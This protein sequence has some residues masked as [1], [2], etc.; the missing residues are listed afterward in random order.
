LALRQP[1]QEEEEP[2]ANKKAFALG[3]C[4]LVAALSV[5][6]T[7]GATQPASARGCD[8][9]IRSG[10]DIARKVE[11]KPAG[12]T[13]CLTGRYRL[14]RPVSPRERQVFR[15]PASI[16]GVKGND[17]G[18]LVSQKGV[19]F[20]NLVMSGFTE[21]AIRCS[22]GTQIIGGRYH[23]NGVNGIGCGLGREGRGV[24]ISGVE[25]DH[26]GSQRYVFHSSAGIKIL[27][28]P[29]SVV[30]RSYVHDN[31]GN[32]IWFDRDSGSSRRDVVGRNKVVRN[33]MRGIFYEVSRGHAVIRRNVVTGNN[34]S[35]TL[36]AS[37]I[38]V[39]SSK[40]VKIWGNTVRD[41]RIWAIRSNEI[42]RGYHLE[43]VHIY[44]N[45]VKG[46]LYGCHFSG[47]RCYQNG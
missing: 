37:G 13:F 47:V 15:G 7:S 40:N 36:G 17:T 20:Y 41:N 4:V 5:V 6:I 44:D 32:G 18:F 31:I 30:R 34:T 9:K 12:T 42:D 26:N 2:M 10:R 22:N 16:V 43:N 39:S 11:A 46:K 1:T 35:L 28:S 24:L 8:V 33:S 45:V 3:A 25:V 19:R 27:G 38:G 23:H 29:G 21:R 14:A